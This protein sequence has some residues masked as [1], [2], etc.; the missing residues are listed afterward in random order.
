[1]VSDAS[2]NV[3]FDNH[4]VYP[5][6][7]GWAD[8]SVLYCGQR[9][10]DVVGYGMNFSVPGTGVPLSKTPA[11]SLYSLVLDGKRLV[12]YET[13]PNQGQPGVSRIIVRDLNAGTSKVIFES[14][15]E[16]LVGDEIAFVAPDRYMVGFV[17]FDTQEVSM[18]ILDFAT[19]ARV[20]LK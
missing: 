11:N 9:G 14:P 7:I 6:L 18:E 19:G 4:V 3:I 13:P 1:M 10:T 5:Q 20:K 16:A 8:S 17:N 2:G 15:N 12:T